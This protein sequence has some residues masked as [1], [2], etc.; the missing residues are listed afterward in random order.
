MRDDAIAAAWPFGFDQREPRQGLTRRTGPLCGNRGWIAL[1]LATTIVI[2]WPRLSQPLPGT[3][4]SRCA[5]G[6]SSAP[7]VSL[8]FSAD[9]QTLATTDQTG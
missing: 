2:P 9:G 5:A 1:L 7:I 3:R 4:P 8:A 6:V